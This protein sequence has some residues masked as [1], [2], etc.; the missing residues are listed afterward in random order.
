MGREEESD[1]STARTKFRIN[2]FALKRGKEE[3]G[4]KRARKRK[5]KW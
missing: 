1:K 2:F 4:R 3:K 5:S